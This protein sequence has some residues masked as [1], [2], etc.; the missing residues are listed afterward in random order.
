M[1]RVETGHIHLGSSILHHTDGWET[2]SQREGG[3]KKKKLGTHRNTG[4]TSSTPAFMHAYEQ[5][6]TGELRCSVCLS[7]FKNT[8]SHADSAC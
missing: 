1:A 8:C 7:G 6:K 4:T 3:E 2:K 5:T